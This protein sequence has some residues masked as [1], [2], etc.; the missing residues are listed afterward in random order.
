M[1]IL[2][3]DPGYPIYALDVSERNVALGGGSNDGG[4]IGIPMYLAVLPNVEMIHEDHSPRKVKEED[5]PVQ[6]K[7]KTDD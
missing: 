6:K 3:Q 4:F 7:Q 5:P 2:M 1:A